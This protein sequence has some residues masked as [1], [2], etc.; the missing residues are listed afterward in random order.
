MTGTPNA[1]NFVEA[2]V[3]TNPVSAQNLTA[4]VTNGFN[5]TTTNFTVTPTTTTQ[6]NGQYVPVDAVEKAREQEKSKLYP[7]I[8]SLKEE[9]AALKR[10]KDEREAAE[11][12]MRAEAEAD[13]KRRA[14]QD[15]D[16]RELLQ[17]KEQEWNEKLEAE[18]LERERAMALLDQERHFQELQAY[19]TQRIESERDNIMPELIDLVDGSTPEEI[20]SSIQSLKDR[21]S[22]ILDSA[23]QAMTSARRDMVGTRT[24]SPA[25]GPLDTNSER[26]FSPEDIANM[27]LSEYQ[28]YRDRLL[29]SSASSRGRGL[30]G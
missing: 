11:A 14:E 18:R 17:Q 19:R 28:K 2:V 4:D 9:L 30:F 25:A 1:Q 27:S 20:E 7:Q 23:Q 8:E 22:R 21:T 6:P 16:V 24:T 5:T 26:Q 15:M 3:E 12:Q 13:A 10:E 29:G